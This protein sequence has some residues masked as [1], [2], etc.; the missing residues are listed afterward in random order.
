MAIIKPFSE[1]EREKIRKQV[2]HYTP[3][4]RDVVNRLLLI[5]TEQACHIPSTDCPL[6]GAVDILETRIDPEYKV[7][8]KTPTGT[9]T[10]RPADVEMT[11][12]ACCKE[13]FFDKKQSQLLDLK[14]KNQ[15]LKHALM[16]V[17][18]GAISW[19]RD[20]GWFKIGA[21]TFDDVCAALEG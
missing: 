11:Y 19:D 3:E 16:K 20:E 14:V 15:K 9:V 12:C 5:I 13:G 18:Q 10:Y 1:A 2:Q 17:K 7:E 6:C 8:Q 21:G 4:V